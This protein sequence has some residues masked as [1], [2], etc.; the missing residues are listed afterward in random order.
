MIQSF[1]NIF[2][3]ILPCSQRF[4]MIFLFSWFFSLWESCKPA[5][6]KKNLWLLRTWISLSCKCRGQDLTLR[7]R[8][9]D[10]FTNV[11]INMIGSFDWQYRGDDGDIFHCNF[12]GKFC[13]SLYQGKFSVLSSYMF[14]ICLFLPWIIFLSVLSMEFWPRYLRS[15]FQRLKISLNIKTFLPVINCKDVFA[16]LP[17]GHRKSII[18]IQ[19]IPDVCKYLYLLSYSNP[20][21]VIILVVCPLKSLVD[22]RI[23]ELQSRGISAANLSSE[24]VDECNL[25]QKVYMPF[26]LLTW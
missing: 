9:V 16:I 11:Q 19:L 21:H 26:C 10:I 5:A 2:T 14:K 6:R 8:L 20:H 1:E 18:I 7:L 12:W 3:N 25:L 17:T 23:H 15:I 13:L 24:G 4:S 22:Y